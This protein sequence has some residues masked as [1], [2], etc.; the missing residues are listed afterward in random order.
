MCRRPEDQTSSSNKGPNKQINNVEKE[1]TTQSEDGDVNELHKNINPDFNSSTDDNFVAT[2]SIESK[3]IE[4]INISKSWN[5]WGNDNGGFGKLLY[6]YKWN[7]ILPCCCWQNSFRFAAHMHKSYKR[8]R[9]H[10]YQYWAKTLYSIT[11]NNRA[12]KPV[13]FIVV[14]DGHKP[15][16]GRDVFHHIG[17]SIQQTKIVTIGHPQ[18]QCPLKT[19][20][21]KDFPGLETRVSASQ[22]L[23]G[24]IKI[25]KIFTP[26]HQKGQRLPINLLWKVI[27]NL[28]RN[29]ETILQRTYHKIR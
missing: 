28:H 7:V 25:S 12:A 11:I 6:I 10:S 27:R 19:R 21:H 16:L 17:F 13:D 4:P 1:E 24:S 20:I 5:F 29:S 26:T 22:K 15:Q 3:I 8:I 18:N 2:I 23:C 9:I 14:K